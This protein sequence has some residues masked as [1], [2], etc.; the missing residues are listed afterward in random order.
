MLIIKKPLNIFFIFSIIFFTIE[1]GCQKKLVKMS[2]IVYLPVNKN[3]LYTMNTDGLGNTMLLETDFEPQWPRWSPDGKEI[4]F[5]T[6]DKEYV[7]VYSLN[8]ID[9][10]LKK[11]KIS[12]SAELPCW[13]SDGRNIAFMSEDEIGI[14]ISSLDGNVLRTIAGKG[15]N[16]AYQSWSPKNDQLVFES[17][18]DGN[19]EIYTI[20]PVTGKELKR[21]TNNKMLDEWPSFSKD[22][23]LIAWVRGV[24]GDK[25]IWVM[26]KDGSHPRQISQNINI[27]DG[28]PSFSPDG[29]ELLFQSSSEEEP[30][31]INIINL[32]GSD[33][34]K[35]GEGFFPNWSPFLD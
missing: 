31:S 3:H 16:G 26:N 13:S 11:I 19:P 34:R 33:L 2:R 9:G 18:R 5:N 25:N 6:Y 8:F 10:S 27:G 14:V 21:L 17:G 32:D 24:E 12:P 4:L 23:S 1:M 28:F 15:I 29:S 7:G 30:A 22:G 20:N 35:I